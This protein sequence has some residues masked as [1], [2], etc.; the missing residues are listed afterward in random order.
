M[1]WHTIFKRQ[2]KGELR[3]DEEP[4]P[5]RQD[6][7]GVPSGGP[8]IGLAG[9]GAGEAVGAVGDDLAS[10]EPPSDPAR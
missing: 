4:K 7:M 5:V 9:I 6:T 8:V 10:F 1:K 2:S 3:R